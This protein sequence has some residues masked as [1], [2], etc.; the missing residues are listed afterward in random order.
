MEGGAQDRGM[1]EGRGRRGSGRAGS[2]GYGPGRGAS[3]DGML[4]S[5]VSNQWCAGMGSETH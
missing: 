5:A 4:G 1:N 2:G 3:V